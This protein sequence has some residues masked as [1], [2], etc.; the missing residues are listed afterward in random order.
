M[1]SSTRHMTTDPYNDCSDIFVGLDSGGGPVSPHTMY[2]DLSK[3][4]CCCTCPLVSGPP[5]SPLRAP[6]SPRPP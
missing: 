5:R 3:V 2:G 6:P 4:L 1:L